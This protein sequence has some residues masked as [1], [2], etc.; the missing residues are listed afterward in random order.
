MS[1]SGLSGYNIS[2]QKL[3]VFPYTSSEHLE[4]KNKNLIIFKS[5]ER[6]WNV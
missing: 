1:F 6:K 3:I 4:L 2:K 5:L